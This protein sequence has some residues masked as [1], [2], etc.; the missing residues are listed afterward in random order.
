V[1]EH[2]YVDLIGVIPEDQYVVVSTNKGEP[3]V[4]NDKSRAGAAFDNVARR[5][6]GEEVPILPPQEPS[7]WGRIKNFSR[8]IF[9]GH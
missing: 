9:S 3:I 8:G 7:W 1:A 6:V 5:I 4:L 2:L